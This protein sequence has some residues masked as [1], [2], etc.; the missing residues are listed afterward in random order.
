MPRHVACFEGTPCRQ[1]EHSNWLARVYFLIFN[2]SIFY[3]VQRPLA[4]KMSGRGGKAPRGRAGFNSKS[5]GI[6]LDRFARAKKSTYDPREVKEKERAR[7]AITVAKY[8]KLKKRL[9]LASDIPTSNQP[10]QQ[11]VNWLCLI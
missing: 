11:Q 1:S 10:P 3:R 4:K 6:S 2:S 5:G 7:A 8:K 9:Q